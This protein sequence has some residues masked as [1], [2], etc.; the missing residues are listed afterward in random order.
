MGASL[1]CGV[2]WCCSLQ[3]E[4][5]TAPGLAG[6]CAL[7]ARFR[8][9]TVVDARVGVNSTLSA[10]AWLALAHGALTRKP[11]QAN[12]AVSGGGR[13]RPVCGRRAVAYVPSRR[14]GGRVPVSEETTAVANPLASSLGAT[15]VLL[16]ALPE[17]QRPFALQLHS[18]AVRG[19][20]VLLGQGTSLQN[21]SLVGEWVMEP[22]AWPA[23]TTVVC[24]IGASRQQGLHSVGS[25]VG[26]QTA[27][28]PPQLSILHAPSMPGPQLGLG[29]RITFISVIG[30][31]AD[32]RYN[33]GASR[34]YRERA[35]SRHRWLLRR[36]TGGLPLALFF[37]ALR[38]EA[39]LDTSSELLLFLHA[40]LYLPDSFEADLLHAVQRLSQEDPHW[41]LA[42]FFGV[43]L[44]W[45]PEPANWPWKRPRVVGRGIDFYGRYRMGAA[46][47]S[48]AQCIDETALLLRSRH[49]VAPSPAF[50]ST[51][52]ST[53]RIW[54]GGTDTVLEGLAM[55]RK[56]Y[57]LGVD[58]LHS[59]WDRDGRHDNAEERKLISIQKFASEESTVLHA[60]AM[61]YMSQKFL[62]TG[63]VPMQRV[64]SQNCGFGQDFWMHDPA[65]LEG[66]VP[67]D[68][69]QLQ[70]KIRERFGP[71]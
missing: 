58:V 33:L 61:S 29:S 2:G 44:D 47:S 5:A 38:A 26:L 51:L 59:I 17:P 35:S 48:A 57:I 14:A 53:D 12:C 21:E 43:P 10:L 49:V 1:E 39:E 27:S 63:R 32:F 71:S 67:F 28:W 16:L 7:G 19:C 34:V 55:G 46:N 6:L 31:G 13:S 64:W 18:S 66:S 69:V 40:D 36:S 9:I 42:G 45:Q 50:D 41:A 11:L 68:W 15:D 22:G 52:P 3:Q 30:D 8:H 54:L 4:R 23:D 70:A 25:S 56:S 65:Q 24:R 62:W 37:G 60:K 20:V